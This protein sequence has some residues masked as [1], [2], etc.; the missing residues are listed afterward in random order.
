MTKNLSLLL[1]MGC[2]FG[3]ST[4]SAEAQKRYKHLKHARTPEGKS[5]V[6]K[7][8]PLKVETAPV[9][10]LPD[11]RPVTEEAFAIN[12]PEPI[13]VA[14]EPELTASIAEP[15]PVPVANETRTVLKLRTKAHRAF[16]QA[17]K[18]LSTLPFAKDIVKNS[19]L[20]QL[21][22]QKQQ[23]NG[24][25]FIIIGC[26]ILGVAL[27]FGIVGLALSIALALSGTFPWTLI[28]NYI[29]L[30]LFFAGAALLTVGIIFRIKEK[31]AAK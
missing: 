8:Q 27:I 10:E 11:F 20:E 12:E 22:P 25:N 17:E 14:S 24:L 18:T 2:F 29:G 6:L 26:I 15:A 9:A 31:R 28:F 7:A 13:P 19:G 30:L 1:I 3:L 4:N 5:V 16:S 21:N 23:V